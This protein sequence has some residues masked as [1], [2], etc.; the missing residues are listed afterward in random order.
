M[1]D[2]GKFGKFVIVRIE[3]VKKSDYTENPR[4]IED[5]Y[6]CLLR[7]FIIIFLFTFLE[8]FYYCIIKKY[9]LK[10]I[11][12]ILALVTI[13][14][15]WSEMTFFNKKPVLSIFAI[16][17]TGARHN[18]NYILIEVCSKMQLLNTRIVYFL[19]VYFL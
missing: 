18:Y 13:V 9:S 5:P 8:W 15:I 2:C 7:Y 3:K 19:N 6:L 4:F 16:L 12:V 14:V 11:S 1:P 10:L 17:L